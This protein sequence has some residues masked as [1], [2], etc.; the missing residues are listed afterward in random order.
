[1]KRRPHNAHHRPPAASAAPAEVRL[2]SLWL[3]SLTGLLVATPLLPSEAAVTKG[4]G[5]VL[6]MLWLLL[7]V[8]WS[9]AK[10]LRKQAGFHG[11]ATTWSFGVVLVLIVASAVAMHSQG[12]ARPMLNAVWQW[13][14][15]GVAFVLCRQTFRTGLQ[16][17]AI[18]SVM[19]ALAVCLSIHGF[20]Q[21]F[22]SLPQT[23]RDYREDP[24]AALA[25]AGLVAPPGSPARAQFESRLNSTEPLATF[26]LTNSLAGF[27]SPW[28]LIAV[29]T[30][31]TSW[32]NT[33]LR[34]RT[35]PGFVFCGVVIS[36]CWIL[37]KSRTATLATLFGLTLLVTYLRRSGWRPDWR[38]MAGL[39][40]APIALVGFGLLVGGLDLLVLTESVKS[41]RYRFEYWQATAAMIAD[42]PWFGCGPGNFQQYYTAYKLPGASEVI[43]DPH[44]FILE[45]WATAGTPAGV[46]L[47]VML[48]V[49]ATQ[50]RRA[51]A[52][53]RPAAEEAAHQPAGTSQATRPTPGRRTATSP[54]A[55]E[56][57]PRDAWFVYLGAA[58]GVLIA[59]FPCGF[60]VGYMPDFA[61]LAI[62]FPS[63]AVALWTCHA[64]VAQGR[65]NLT[66][67][68][69]A[70]A[71][72]L[73][74]LLA[75]GGMT[76]AGVSMTLWL[77]LALVLNMA[78]A[79]AAS[80]PRSPWPT[81]GLATAAW[82][83]LILCHQT[84][85]VPILSSSSLLAE[86]ATTR[87]LGRYVQAEAILERAAAADPYS[88]D[89]W[90]Q[91]AALRHQR[92]LLSDTG[93]PPAGFDAAVSEMSRRNPRSAG[94]RLQ[95][96]HWHVMAYRAKNLDEQLKAARI[97]YHEA[98]GLYP[99]NSVGHAHAAWATYLAEGPEA[100]QAEAAAAIQLD[101]V[102]PHREQKLAA[103]T[104]SDPGPLWFTDQP[105]GPAEDCEQ[106]MAFLRTHRQ[107]MASPADQSSPASAAQ[108]ATVKPQTP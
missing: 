104:I 19:L 102:N 95:V 96:G 53:G 49:F 93:P 50:V 68:C 39:V 81:W 100:A 4:S 23:R 29:G 17:R 80:G 108:P 31:W 52:T 97:A 44:N 37:T 42:Y 7:L 79:P 65:L 41:L 75:A 72:L 11:G 58:V 64:W 55:A 77:L 90:L 57:D 34:W 13:L 105:R 28:L 21:T 45:V 101:D 74:N 8:A 15:F 84:A 22:Y 27:L 16:Q 43:G 40:V 18:V 83:L 76:F 87:Q 86:A 46:A 82:L 66:L 30:A 78:C 25:E 99:N 89:P 70:I 33:Q 60:L 85:Y 69:C 91:L 14:S 106:T 5:V 2:Q 9:T 48:L 73:V 59:F 36:A 47:L 32:R 35:L 61:L 26:T 94:W 88:A 103:Q 24:E 62:A 54:A 10:V 107:G 1:M 6:V 56:G 98:I 20:Y 63:G 12:H 38:F 71:A 3:A 51:L 67:L 92:W